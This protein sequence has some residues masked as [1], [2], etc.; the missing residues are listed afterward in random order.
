MTEP[1]GDAL[2][3]SRENE[4]VTSSTGLL[5]ERVDG[6]EEVLIDGE[7][8]SDDVMAGVEVDSSHGQACGDGDLL[9]VLGVLPVADEQPELVEVDEEGER[10][11]VAKP[12]GDRRLPDTWWSI[13]EDERGDTSLLAR[14]QWSRRR[15]SALAASR[16]SSLR[17]SSLGATT[18]QAGTSARKGK[19]SA[20]P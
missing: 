6:R 15:E 14:V 10:P 20:S 8:R 1:S 18:R 3:T 12:P 11:I 5:H 13:Q 9:G 16:L 17:S 19:R 7:L 2:G 4:L